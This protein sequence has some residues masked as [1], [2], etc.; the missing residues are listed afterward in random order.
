MP[1]SSIQF[2]AEIGLF[3][4]AMYSS[5]R[6]GTLENSLNFF[7]WDSSMVPSLSH[8]LSFLLLLIVFPFVLLCCLIF[9][10][11]DL[12]NIFCKSYFGIY[13]SVRIIQKLSQFNIMRPK[14]LVKVI[15]QYA[16]FFQLCLLLPHINIYLMM[17]GDIEAN[18]GPLSKQNLSLCHWN[19]NS[20]CT[21]DFIKVTLLE[22][23]LAVHDFD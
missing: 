11:T 9:G 4:N 10:L 2:R 19:L 21:R 6:Y 23:Y 17:C 16:F 5:S 15:M 7:L 1:I 14:K 22:A 13:F 8:T 18:P 3:Y 20:I 12:S